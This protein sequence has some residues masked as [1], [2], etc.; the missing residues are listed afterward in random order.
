MHKQ[1]LGLLGSA[2]LGAGLGAGLMYL[3]DPEDGGHRRALARRK[4][5]HAL[6]KGSK[7]ARRTSRDLGKRARS[8]A[9]DA[10][11]KLRRG[12]VDKRVLSK[13]GL[14]AGRL[15]SNVRAVKEARHRS[16]VDER[17][18][19]RRN[20]IGAALGAVSLGLLAQNLTHRRGHAL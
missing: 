12:A 20:A 18:L 3:L 17:R 6:R 7:A 1:R 8:L 13:M 9:A 10:G 16:A 14:V 2:G 11:S 4:A 19:G 5:M 15:L